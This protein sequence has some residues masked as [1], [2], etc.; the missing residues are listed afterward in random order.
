M[1]RNVLPQG[2]TLPRS[3]WLTRHRTL[4][5]LLWLHALVL[6]VFG[7]VRGYGFLHSLSEG[8]AIAVVGGLAL[9]AGARPRLAAA[10]VSFGLVSSS[11][12]LV[13]LSGGVIE[14][15]FHFFVVIVLLTL[16]EDWVPFLLAA[17][18]VAFHHGILGALDPSSVYNHP[19]AIAH[20]WRWAAIHAAFV[21]AAGIA[22]VAAWRLNEAVRAETKE[23]Y[24][25]AHESEQRFKSAFEEAPVGMGLV[26][27]LPDSAGR[28][29]HVNRAMSE[30][31]GYTE[32][33]LTCLTFRDVTHPDDLE[34]SV[35][36]FTRLVAGDATN[37]DLEK[38]YIRADGNVIWGL[39]HV[40]LVRDGSGNPLY[41]IGQIQD[42][43]ER[44][45]ARERL[46][47][48]ALHDQLTGLSNRRKLL[49]DLEELLE[50]SGEREAQLLLFDLDG[51]KAY[52]DTF[53]HPAG[54]VL[55]A[56][57]AQRLDR[58]VRGRGYA[59]RMGGDEFCVLALA[60][61]EGPEDLAA[62]A[63][64]AL[65]EQGDGFRITASHGAVLLPR[66]ASS[67]AEALG[68]ADQ[69]M[70]ARKSTSRDSA[71]QDQITRALITVADERSATLRTHL[72]AVKELCETVGAKL[73]VSGTQ[74]TSLR[75]A[76]SLHDIGKIAVPD[77]ILNKPGPLTP[78]EW[79]FI[80]RHT[81]IGER[82]VA[83]TPALTHVAKLIRSSHERYD[84]RGY[85]DRLAGEDIPL[86]ARIILVCDAFE[87]MTSERPYGEKLTHAAALEEIRRCAGTQ[88]DPVVVEAFCA[89]YAESTWDEVDE[90]ATSAA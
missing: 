71:Q 67:S 61:P 20:P 17:V 27:I 79:E 78:D 60:G 39:I 15:H 80:R 29:L 5:A 72:D 16:Y 59:Y 58:A 30:L 47:H 10:L 86:G 41:A 74:L 90:A 11:A 51:F 75:Q 69:R 18:Y 1:I 65:A 23:A 43:T 28:L 55:L 63:A 45:T 12:V 53:G 32:E 2:R 26:S 73:G 33:E 22:S 62:A 48:Q 21:A 9:L 57:L 7:T 70:Y 49:D 85:P 4:S 87:A 88:F 56:R 24:R 40:S 81:L 36:S 13:H 83:A 8:M 64:A 31:L 54:D 42:V 14:A 6:P 82:I 84:G 35:A 25:Q 68:K 77:T 44:K 19:D 38:R 76:A 89:A 46:A 52:N 66:E 50:R 37:Y 34:E 3:A